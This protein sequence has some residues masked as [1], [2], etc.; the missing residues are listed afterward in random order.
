MKKIRLLAVLAML[1]VFTLAAAGWAAEDPT[2]FV[3]R[4]Q[5]ALKSAT[6]LDA[7][8]PFY[9]ASM[10][11]MT[12]GLKQKIAD[13]R[14]QQSQLNVVKVT[15]KGNK[16]EVALKGLSVDK[17]AKYEATWTLEEQGG[18]WVIDETSAFGEPL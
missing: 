4:Y 8:A 16:V 11:E 10:M 1:S 15:R 12:R 9:S 14:N 2:A 6:S 7:L 17:K 13:I 3:K 18:S 5:A